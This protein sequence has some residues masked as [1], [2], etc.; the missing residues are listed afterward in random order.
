MSYLRCVRIVCDF[1]SGTLLR[2]TKR[3]AHALPTDGN[4]SLQLKPVEKKVQAPVTH[5]TRFLF[6]LAKLKRQRQ[7][8]EY[9]SCVTKR[10]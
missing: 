7:Y 10:G 2:L 3:K 8:R 6:S 5:E 4:N 9:T 1:C